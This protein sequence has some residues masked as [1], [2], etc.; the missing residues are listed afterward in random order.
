MILEAECQKCKE[1]FIPENEEDT[2]H[3]ARE[4]G[5]PCGGEGVI[6]GAWQL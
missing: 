4:D 1:V 3:I 2:E 6:Y 5:T